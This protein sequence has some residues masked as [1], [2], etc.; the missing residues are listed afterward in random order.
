MKIRLSAL[1]SFFFCFGLYAQSINGIKDK[2]GHYCATDERHDQLLKSDTAYAARVKRINS[3]HAKRSTQRTTSNTTIYYIPVVVHIIHENGPENISDQQ[4]MDGMKHLNDAYSHLPP[5]DGAGGADIGIQFCLASQDT[6]GNPTTGIVRLQSDLTNVKYENDQALFELDRWNTRKYM[7]IW[8]VK[9]ICWRAECRVNGYSSLPYEHGKTNDG[10]V[11]KAL[12]FGRWENLSKIPIHETGHYFNL[13]H[14]FGSCKNDD[15]THDGDGVCDTPPDASSEEIPCGTAMNSC[16]TDEDDHS[17]NNPFRP[18]AWGGLGE[19]N[20]QTQ[21]YMDYGNLDCIN[22]F[23]GGQKT[24]MRSALMDFRNSLLTSTGCKPTCPFSV[25]FNSSAP[26]VDIDHMVSFTNTST[27]GTRF[28]WEIDDVPFSTTKNASYTFQVKGIHLIRLY[29]S[30][31]DSSCL[32][33][34]AVPIR[35]IPPCIAPTTLIYSSPTIGIYAKKGSS[36]YLMASWWGNATNFKWEIDDLLLSNDPNVRYT[37]NQPG[38]HKIKLLGFNYDVDCV[39]STE[40]N[41]NIKE[42]C[43]SSHVSFTA[44]SLIVNPGDTISLINTSFNVTHFSWT[45]D[46]NEF[47]NQTN[48]SY[49]ATASGNPTI[50]LY[51][52]NDDTSCIDYTSTAINVKCPKLHASFDIPISVNENSVV[53]FRNTSSGATNF[54]WKRDG[55]VF[56]CATEP[57]YIFN[58]T[59]NHT[60][61]LTALNAVPSCVDTSSASITI[62]PYCVACFTPL[63]SP[64]EVTL[65]S[66]IDFNDSCGTAAYFIWELDGIQYNT[67]GNTAFSYL[68]NVPG[69]HYLNLTAHNLDATCSNILSTQIKVIDTSPPKETSIIIPNLITA[70]GD[71]L[72][73][74][75]QVTGLSQGYTL[76]VYNQW[77]SMVYKKEN[78]DNSFDAQSLNS[79]IYFYNLYHPETGKTYR[80]WVHVVK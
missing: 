6:L 73:D 2:L 32:V 17:L 43:A 24:R 57:E 39:D 44:S 51:A 49:I 61:E 64:L 79:N 47:S 53:H 40:L 72:N 56:S 60:I 71:G 70:N 10:V 66:T 45:I 22:L 48:A 67:G 11:I 75:F 3:L 80:G 27:G 52:Y 34:T 5:F 23:T 31:E 4:V 50:T 35:V 54:V 76:E 19:Q 69:D 21:N 26:A 74:T 9:E 1:L 38:I 18:A 59:G 33:S 8:L 30:N 58:Q 29:A 12:Q 55:V 36:F 77:D 37:F 41:V 62:L 7:N 68:F 65:G 46:G 28:K 15:C 16:T 42:P 25:S 13:S 78:Y 14:T 20:D 63:G